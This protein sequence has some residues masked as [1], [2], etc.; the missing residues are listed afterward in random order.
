MSNYSSIV[1]DFSAAEAQTLLLLLERK[2]GVVHLDYLQM[3]A[4]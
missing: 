1:G 3:A 4:Q 2:Q